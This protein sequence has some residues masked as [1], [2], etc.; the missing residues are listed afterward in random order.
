MNCSGYWST[1]LGCTH[2]STT[3]CRPLLPIQSS[4]R[5]SFLVR[6][7]LSADHPNVERTNAKRRS[8][9]QSPRYCLDSFFKYRCQPNREFCACGRSH[10]TSFSPLGFTLW[11]LPMK[12]SSTSTVPPLPSKGRKF[13]ERITLPRRYNSRSGAAGSGAMH[14]GSSLR[15]LLTRVPTG[16]TASAPA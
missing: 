4:L 12:V 11:S 14:W 3:C 9:E 10:V 5:T 15:T 16:C 8:C 6:A 2:S 13:A 1:R 7:K